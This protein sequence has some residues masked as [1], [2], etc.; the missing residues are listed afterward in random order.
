[1]EKVKRFD[2][3]RGRH[4]GLATAAYG[5]ADSDVDHLKLA[6]RGVLVNGNERARRRAVGFGVACEA[7]D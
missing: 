4:G 1:M 7:W 5:N 6:D 3:L 2:E